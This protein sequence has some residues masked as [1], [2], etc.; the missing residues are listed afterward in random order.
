MPK[1]ENIGFSEKCNHFH[2][3]TERLQVPGGWLYRLRSRD[4]S[5]VDS[6]VSLGFVPDPDEAEARNEAMFRRHQEREWA[7]QRQPILD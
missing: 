3:G 6:F 5:N 2:T 1:W 7:H 4:Y